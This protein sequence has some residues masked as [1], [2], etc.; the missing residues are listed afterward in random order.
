MYIQC[1]ID[2]T[3]GEQFTHGL[4]YWADIVGHKIMRFV[5]L[6]ISDSK[7][8]KYNNQVYP[9]ILQIVFGTKKNLFMLIY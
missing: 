6:L 5:I 9:N 7:N 8:Y 3:E 1:Y 2:Q 4:G